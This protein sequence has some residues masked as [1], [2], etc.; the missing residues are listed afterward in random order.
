MISLNQILRKKQTLFPD[1]Q[2]YREIHSLL[3]EA[4]A[5]DRLR[6]PRSKVNHLIY[7][8]NGNPITP[9]WNVLLYEQNKRGRRALITC[10]LWTL[11]AVL[12]KD[13]E[14]LVPRRRILEVD[15]A[16]WGSPVG[17]VMVGVFEGDRMVTGLAPH[18]VYRQCPFLQ[19][20]HCAYAAAGLEAVQKLA[21][22]PDPDLT[23]LICTGGANERLKVTLRKTGYHVLVTEI[24][25]QAQDELENAYARYLVGLTGKRG[26]YHD[27]KTTS[28]KVVAAAYHS[29]VSD[30]AMFP[31]L[32]TGWRA[33]AEKRTQTFREAF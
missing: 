1:V 6:P 12:T 33:L 30:P 22:Y 16:G 7:T 3:E 8:G 23:I 5:A 13:W 9:K 10:D 26:L 20:H 18:T 28:G 2:Q 14:I 31:Y 21:P 19:A 24:V 29:L 15:D 25:G 17:G 4:V 11:E 32:K 27:P